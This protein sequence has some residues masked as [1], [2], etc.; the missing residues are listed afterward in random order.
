MFDPPSFVKDK[1]ILL[2]GNAPIDYTV[3][4]DKYSCVIRMNKGGEEEILQ[5]NRCDIWVNNLG[6]YYN[7]TNK[8]WDCGTPIM[9]MNYEHNGVRANRY[10][11]E[12]LPVTWFW[13]VT[14]FNSMCEAL[15]LPRPSTGLMSL[16]YFMHYSTADI[17]IAGYDSYKTHNKYNPENTGAP[18]HDWE[19]EAE[20]INSWKLKGLIK[21]AH[22][23]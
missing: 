17:T 3:P 20:L 2:I 13:N 8:V 22:E 11:K 12:F 19:K 14:E 15:G 9:R 6:Y 7:S 10:P 18:V 5:G 23:G 21:E 16:Y 4:L 1:R